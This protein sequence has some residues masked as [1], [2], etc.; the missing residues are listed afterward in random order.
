MVPKRI[1]LTAWLY[2]TIA[3]LTLIDAFV[4]A[5]VLIPFTAILIIAFVVIEFR[6]IPIAQKIAGGGLIVIG[7]LGAA[8]SENGLDILI[9]GIARSRIF[10][11]VVFRSL[12]APVSSVSEP[13]TK[14]LQNN[15]H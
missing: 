15:N 8:G 11:T 3:T 7:I 10:F 2:F 1:S 5:P 13:S 12:L 6:L 9:D 14:S 4:Q